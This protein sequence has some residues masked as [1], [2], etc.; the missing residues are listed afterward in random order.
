VTL[1]PAAGLLLA[2]VGAILRYTRRP[3]PA[4]AAAPAP[5]NAAAAATPPAAPQTAPA[6]APGAYDPTKLLDEGK[7]PSDVY[8]AEARDP[9]W[10]DPVETIIGGRMRA[11]IE[12]MVP[13][14]G[15]VLKCHRLSCLVGID[16]PADKREAALA[17]SKFITLGP[18]TVDLDPEPDG[19]L[20]WLFFSEARMSDA[21]A[22]TDWYK[23]LRK[24]TLARIRDGKAPNPL[25]VP[26][27]ELPR[28]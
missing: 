27:A 11:D 4:E 5:G 17:V 25:P 16:A 2:G 24:A 22:F 23:K 20:R 6:P 1:I 19:T 8:L 14:A 26:I 9:D 28:E 7:Q 18:V 15:V 12:G 13:G 21:A 10:A 3:E